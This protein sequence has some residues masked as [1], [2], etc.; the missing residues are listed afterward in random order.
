[1]IKTDKEI[2]WRPGRLYIPAT[3][4]AGLVYEAT[5]TAG[6]K[7]AGTGTATGANLLTTEVNTSGIAGLAM[8]TAA[9]SVSHLMEIPADLDLA[10]PLYAQVYWTANNTSGSTDWRVLYKPYIA[11]TTVLGTAEAAT[12]PGVVGAAQTMAAVAYTVMRTPNMKIFGNILPDTTEMLQ[13]NVV[14]NALV[15]ITTTFFLGLALRYTPKR[16]G[17]GDNMTEAKPALYIG[18]Q[19]FT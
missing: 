4:F 13:L 19:K 14:M 5:A 2:L 3:S 8:T 12:A 9:N 1:M 11:G 16:L 18:S 17:N 10:F 15:T 6:I 7:S